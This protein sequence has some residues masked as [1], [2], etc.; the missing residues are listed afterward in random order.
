MKNESQTRGWWSSPCQPTAGERSGSSLVA[1]TSGKPA[2]AAPT[3]SA[4]ANEPEN[5]LT[6]A[7]ARA[8]AATAAAAVPPNPPANLPQAG[9]ESLKL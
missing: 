5:A 9:G 2:S 4:T 3:S 8:P 1:P 7:F 6:A